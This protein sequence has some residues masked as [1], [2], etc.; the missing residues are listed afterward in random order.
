MCRGQTRHLSVDI[1]ETVL[2]TSITVGE[3]LV[4][5]AHQM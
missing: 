1:G 5:E 2:A 3:T 4:I